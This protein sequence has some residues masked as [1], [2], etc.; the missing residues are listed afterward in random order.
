ML[1]FFI[2]WYQTRLE[3]NDCKYC[4][5]HQTGLYK[6]QHPSHHKNKTQKKKLPRKKEK[7][8]VRFQNNDMVAEQQKDD[9][10]S[11]ESLE[12]SDKAEAK[13][14]ESSYSLDI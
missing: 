13:D 3:K 11:L 6:K 7:K 12:S 14:E 10:I 4:K 2:Y 5:K 1:G 8:T 9:E